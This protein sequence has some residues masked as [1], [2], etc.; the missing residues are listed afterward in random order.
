MSENRIPGLRL[1][2][3][4]DEEVRLR[5]D[6]G[7][8]HLANSVSRHAQVQERLRGELR[9][10]NRELAELRKTLALLRRE[11]E[12]LREIFLS[13]EKKLLEVSMSGQEESK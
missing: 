5:V 3:P 13:L 7:I 2:N 12:R 1:E 9:E 6:K 10:K 11:R 8:H 4:A